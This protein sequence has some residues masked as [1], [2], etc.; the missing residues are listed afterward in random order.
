M[1]FGARL[2]NS[3]IKSDYIILQTLQ[4]LSIDLFTDIFRSKILLKV[5]QKKI[6]PNLAILV[7]KTLL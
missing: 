7:T 3:G 5:L 4:I 6:R 2:N 1:I